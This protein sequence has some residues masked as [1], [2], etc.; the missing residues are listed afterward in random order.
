MSR[1]LLAATAIAA[2]IAAATG[3]PSAAD[4]STVQACGLAGDFRVYSS[5][6]DY[7]AGGAGV[8]PSTTRRLTLTGNRWR[9]GSSSG[10]FRVATITAA[11]W[12]RWGVEKYGPTK[13][14]VFLRWSGTTA[15]GPIEG[16]AR[17]ADFFWLIYAA[18]PPVVRDAGT[19]WLKL[20]HALPR[21]C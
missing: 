15:S 12:K 14:V 4:R 2:A 8:M 9:F 17:R 5:R 16:S 21:S 10:T 11:D 3:G 20:G 6:I 13:K 19:V 18:R 1:A 7:A